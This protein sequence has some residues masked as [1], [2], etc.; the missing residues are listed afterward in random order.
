MKIAIIRFGSLGDCVLLCPF[1]DHLRSSGATE[2]TIISKTAYA[3]LFAIARGADRESSDKKGHTALDHARLRGEP[4]GIALLEEGG[5][6]RHDPAWLAERR[7]IKKLNEQGVGTS[8]YYPKP[9]PHFDYYRR[10]YGFS[11][12]SFPNASA[13]SYGSIALSVGPHLVHEDMEYIAKVFK[14]IAKE[15]L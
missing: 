12:D 4:V 5:T 3:E 6:D 15:I 14:Q 7:R 11:T 9:V 8:I 10:K 2:I 1:I 13:I